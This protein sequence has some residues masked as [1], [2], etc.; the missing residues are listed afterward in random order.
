MWAAACEKLSWVDFLEARLKSF[1]LE[2][3]GCKQHRVPMNIDGP[4][5]NVIH[6]YLLK[7]V[8]ISCQYCMHNLLMNVYIR[9][10]VVPT[11]SSISTCRG[12]K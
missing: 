1:D 9:Y 7:V 6:D 12:K 5:V 8:I 11:S 2:D 10:Y 4:C 3:A